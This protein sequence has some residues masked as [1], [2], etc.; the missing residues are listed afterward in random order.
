MGVIKENGRGGL[1]KSHDFYCLFLKYLTRYIQTC[2]VDENQH[3]LTYSAKNPAK[4][5]CF[6]D[7]LAKN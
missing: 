1:V 5:P 4:I 7:F 6:Y 3:F 2:Y